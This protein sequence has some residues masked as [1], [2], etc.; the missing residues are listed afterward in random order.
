MFVK[1]EGRQTSR[2]LRFHQRRI[3]VIFSHHPN[4]LNYKR[5]YLLAVLLMTLSNAFAQLT[6]LSNLRKKN[7]LIQKGIIQLDSLS[8]VPG[9]FSIPGIEMSTYKLDE[10]NARLQFISFPDTNNLYVIYRV[11]PYRLNAKTQRYNY[12]SIRYNFIAEHPF[13]I[14]TSKAENAIFNFGSLHSEGSF[15]RAL[16]FGNNQDAIVNSSM[17]LQLQGFIGDSLQLTAAITDNN[18]P[19]QPE[20][21]TQDLRDFDRIFLQIKKQKWEVNFGDLDLRQNKNYFLNFYK[22]IQGVSFLTENKIGAVNNTSLISGA[23]A[24]GKFNRQLLSPLEGNQGPYRLRGANNELYFVILAG[25]ERVYIDGQLMQR[26][27][28]QDYVINY[29]TAE[30]TFTPKRLITKDVRIQVEFEYSD[31]NF[32][33]AQI[34]ATNTANWKNKFSITTSYYTNSDAKNSSIDQVLDNRQKQ[35]LSEIGD[36]LS[37]AYYDNSVEDTFAVSKIL[38]EKKDTLYNG[39]LF[40]IYKLSGNPAATLYNVAF[41]Y[42]GPGKGSYMPLRNAT[43]GQSFEWISPNGGDWQPVTLLITPKKLQVLAVGGEYKF[44]PKTIF[45]LEGAISDYDINLFSARDKK[46]D[47][48]V[49]LKLML[50]NEELPLKLFNSLLKFSSAAGY[51]YVANEFRALERLRNVEF[52]RDWSLPY[53]TGAAD[54]NIFSGTFKMEDPKQNFFKYDVTSYNRSDN[55]HGL[56]HVMEQFQNIN[57]YKINSR[58]NNV[59]FNYNQITGNFLRPSINIYKTFKKIN[60]LNVYIKYTGEYNKVQDGNSDTLANVSF[61]FVVYE[62]GIRSN[63]LKLNRWG[64]TYFTRRDQLPVSNK[65]ILTDKS[66]NFLAF[67]ELLKNEKHQVKFN[68][69]YRELKIL[70]GLSRLKPDRSIVG[71]TEYTINEIKGFLT[72]NFLYELGAGQEQRR[73][74]TYVEVPAGQGEYTWIDYNNN[75]IPELNEFELAVFQDQKKYIRVFTPGSSYV[76]ANYLQ[77]NYS[78]ELEPKLLITQTKNKIFKIIKQSSTSSALQ[79][80][81]KNIYN[82][83]FLFNPFRQ[84]LLDTSLISLS[85][86]FSNTL[87]YNRT[88]IKWGFEFTHSKSSSKSLLA[89]GFESRGLQN[90]ISRIRINLNKNFISTVALRKVNNTLATSGA[91]FNNRNYN[92]IQYTAEPSLTYIYKSNFRTVIS[93][94]YTRKANTIDSLERSVNHAITADVRYNIL[95]SSTINAK[96]TYNQINYFGYAGSANS[97]A[98]FILLEGLLPGKNFLWTFD[99]TKQLVNGIEVSLQ[100]EGRRPGDTRTIHTGRASLRAVF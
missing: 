24:K 5:I 35:F 60:S 36:S 61:G 23:V 56:R 97:T 77:F 72:G 92:I 17:N 19:V 91:K 14:K 59:H 58:L 27:E 16:S 4:H 3:C 55:Y 42:L 44:S 53:E 22:R 66:D 88:S 63:D 13:V 34:Y 31:R 90:L 11:F 48:G 100:Y 86:Y 38:Y 64:L 40:P 7:I 81:K 15:G 26:G 52:F 62:T 96:I 89:Y 69:T 39:Q 65:L 50:K 83:N 85:S 8:I 74:F 70:N 95:S 10:M 51:E 78:I 98:G 54:E 6:P 75:G 12:D 84:E 18:L 82:G 57:G 68:F 21:N 46:N 94:A 32:L 47:K 30:I 93:Y 87:Y 99:F 67:T 28:D 43:N 80:S 9:T 76:K 79:I 20:G 71:R 33:N 29:N 41:S 25:T 2:L 49:G 73:E 37:L 1:P 45:S